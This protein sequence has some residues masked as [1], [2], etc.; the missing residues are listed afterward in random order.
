MAELGYAERK[1]GSHGRWRHTNVCS[2]A[3]GDGGTEGPK[4]FAFPSCQRVHQGIPR[5]KGHGGAASRMVRSPVS[6][7]ENKARQ[8][9]YTRM[10]EG[11]GTYTE[12]YSHPGTKAG[13]TSGGR[14]GTVRRRAYRAQSVTSARRPCA[15]GGLEGVR[16]S[17]MV[18]GDPMVKASTKRCAMR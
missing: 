2:H 12:K 11:S 14:G 16:C 4:G 8:C 18:Q 3:N 7:A 15:T 5:G 1:Q 9:V 6:Q 10:E 17:P 13:I